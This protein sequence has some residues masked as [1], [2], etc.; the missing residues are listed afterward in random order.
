MDATGTDASRLELLLEAGVA[1]ASGLEL[2]DL[3]A[4]LVE[5][6]C[7]LTGARYGALGVLDETGRR[8]DRFFTHGMDQHMRDAIG[9]EPV[10]RGILGALIID[11]RPLRLTDLGADPRSVGFPPNH[12][13]M[14]SFLGVPI[15]AGGRVFGNFYLTEKADGE[16][17]EDDERL[18]EL[19]S[20]QAGAAVQNGRVLI[21]SREHAAALERAL[22]E[23]SSVR[24]INE[25]I[26]S[27]RPRAEIL[28]FIASQAATTVHARLVVVGLVD[29]SAACIR[30]EATSGDGSGAFHELEIPLEG[31]KCG[32]A[33]RARR[34]VRVDDAR[35]DPQYGTSVA[36][37]TDGKA[38]LI[39]PLVY[40]DQSEGVLVAI[41]SLDRATFNDDDQQVLELFAAR[42]TLA[43]GMARSLQS[44]RERAEAEVMLLRAEQRE[45]ARRETLRRVVEAQEAERR[46]IA[47]E[48]HDDAG[49]S[50][51]SVLMGLRAAEGSEDPAETRR[52]LGE[53]RETIA[54]SIRDL[55][56]L[57]IELR[58]TALDDFGLRAALE[59]LT[60]TFGRRSGLHIDLQ[61]SGLDVRLPGEV[62]TALYRVVQEALTNIAK[63]AGAAS[64][65]VV[66]QQ[67][68]DRA[69]VVIEDDGC[70][71]EVD[72]AV[73][74]LGLVSMR[75]R[76]E[77]LG[78]TL[79]V[80][81]SPETG[82][83]IAAEV[84]L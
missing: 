30:I 35:G 27:E 76:A 8:L 72:G 62:E 29:P 26:L 53:L 68:S 4:R 61:T 21:D 79:R 81:S 32:M 42:A 57:A 69:V 2:E 34:A 83:T 44:E 47:R 51:A 38:A 41:D 65:S 74:G 84:P 45:Q 66:A 7:K 1:I 36:K 54:G 6:A 14:T 70:G 80:E 5:L 50:L 13:P 40:R 52:L 11:A 59:R 23:L 9:P 25:A 37:A 46:R 28:E 19:F 43:L 49:Q 55:R 78:G 33:V 24:R 60:E 56:A 73:D 18:M 58:P 22:K 12:P 64:V 16:F 31:S 15:V 48:L 67:H 71:F 10:G 39:I 75:E 20:A 3:L 17:S 63:H 77:L 82:T